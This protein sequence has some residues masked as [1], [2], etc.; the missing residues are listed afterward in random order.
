[1]PR[2]AVSGVWVGRAW[3]EGVVDGGGDKR[4][5]RGVAVSSRFRGEARIRSSPFLYA[6]EGAPNSAGPDR[7]VRAL[8]W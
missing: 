4:H 1:V 5:V 7:Q 2:L 8:V 6:R 3:E